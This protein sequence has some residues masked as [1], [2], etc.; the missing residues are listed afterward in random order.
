MALQALHSQFFAGAGG[1]PPPA[2]TPGYAGW[3]SAVIGGWA[4]VFL[5]G[6]C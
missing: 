6:L 2:S 5:L 1:A 4:I 3:Q